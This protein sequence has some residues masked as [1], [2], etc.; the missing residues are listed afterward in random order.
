MYSVPPTCQ[1]CSRHWDRVV[2]NTE[3]ACPHRVDIFERKSVKVFPTSKNTI[4]KTV[5]IGMPEVWQWTGAARK[6]LLR[7]TRGK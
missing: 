2:H 7:K 4:K 6:G 5:Q 3:K 1:H